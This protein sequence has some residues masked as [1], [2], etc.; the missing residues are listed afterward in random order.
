MRVGEGTRGERNPRDLS[1]LLI[2]RTLSV[3]SNLT[4][5][6]TL[7]LRDVDLVAEHQLPGLRQLTD[8]RRHSAV[9]R[10]ALSKARRPRPRGA[11]G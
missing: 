7:Q 5:S 1:K 6:T 11:S 4:L 8:D 9:A 2:L 3:D 10:V